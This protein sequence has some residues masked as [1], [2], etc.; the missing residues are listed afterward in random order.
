MLMITE[1]VIQLVILLT[2]P[3]YHGCLG[4]TNSLILMIFYKRNLMITV[5][6]MTGNV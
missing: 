3:S 4:G 2:D 1:E 6:S 5:L